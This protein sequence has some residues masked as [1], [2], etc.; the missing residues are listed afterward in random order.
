VERE[1]YSLPP[2]PLPHPPLPHKEKKLEKPGRINLRG[3]RQA[4]ALLKFEFN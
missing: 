3:A 4:A 2:L 1:L